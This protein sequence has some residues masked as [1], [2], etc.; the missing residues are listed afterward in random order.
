MKVQ[1]QTKKEAI[2][3]AEATKLY[4]TYAAQQKELEAK[5]KEYKEKI[6]CYAAENLKDF[7]GKTLELPNGVRV[8]KRVTE[9]AVYVEDAIDINWLE[10]AMDYDIAKAIFIKLDAKE[11]G[12]LHFSEYERAL[13]DKIDFS[14]EFK[15]TFAVCVTT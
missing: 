13:L 2:N 5:A 9:K 4:A 12:K 1:K 7:K 6:L 8:E 10:D 14:V 15:E 3:I 11:M